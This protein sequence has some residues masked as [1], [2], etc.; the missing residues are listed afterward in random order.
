MIHLSTH[1]I[2]GKRYDLVAPQANPDCT[3]CAFDHNLPACN[4]APVC[5]E[6]GVWGVFQEAKACREPL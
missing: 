4:R 3:Q 2:D 6:N 5:Q 1:T